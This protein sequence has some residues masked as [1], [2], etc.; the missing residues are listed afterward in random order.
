MKRRLFVGGVGTRDEVRVAEFL[1][2]KNELILY[3]TQDINYKENKDKDWYFDVT[4]E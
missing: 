1:C 3:C 2:T 4:Q